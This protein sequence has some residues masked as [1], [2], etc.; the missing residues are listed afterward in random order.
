MF[1]LVMLL[2]PLSFGHMVFVNNALWFCSFAVIG[3]AGLFLRHL[4]KD[5][6]WKIY[7]AVPAGVSM[8]ALWVILLT[9][10]QRSQHK[11][12]WYLWGGAA[13]VLLM[14][15]AA[16]RKRYK[17]QLISLLIMALGFCLK[18]YYVIS[19]SIYTRQNDVGY[20]D[21]DYGHTGYIEYIYRHMS[22][23][24]FDPR[25]HWQYCHP[26]LHHTISA[27]WL[28]IQRELFA[29]GE[30]PARES[31]QMLSLFYS[32]CVMITAYRILCHFKLKGAALYI[33]LIVINFHPA[34]VLLSGSINND[35]LSIAFI[36][37]AVLCTLKWRESRSMKDILKLALC[38][39]L[40]MMTKISAALVSPPVALM[41]LIVFIKNSKTEVWKLIKQFV[42]FGLVC[43][44]LGMWF[45]VYER[46]RWDVP[47]AYVH[48]MSP[49]S[50]QYIGDMPFSE[51][52]TDFSLSQFSP[53]Y[54][55]WRQTD[56]FGIFYGDTDYNPLI[57][58]LKNCIFGESF[59][60]GTFAEYPFVYYLLPIFFC[61]NLFIAA[62]A[63]LSIIYFSVNKC[64]AAASEKAFIVS[65]YCLMM[66]SFYR[67]AADYP[68]TC[69]MNFRYI[70][71][72]AI[73][74]ALS[75]GF[76]ITALG[77]RR[78]K[79]RQPAKKAAGS[80]KQPEEQAAPVPVIESVPDGSAVITPPAPESAPRRER[81][82]RRM[83]LR[84]AAVCF[85]GASAVCFAL[86]AVTV[87]M[88]LC[89]NM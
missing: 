46:L 85:L 66:A 88:F 20:F 62:M 35:V 32:M 23:P 79:K 49:M 48:E 89:I 83:G 40:G 43:V 15:L 84:Q 38:I 86:C 53:I 51:R 77:R 50:Y 34:F 71:P 30:N 58:L 5:R 45:P 12:V 81:P 24:D 8:A 11:S 52:I 10:Y 59:G 36:M 26:P 76:T 31:I 33:P 63:F 21:K 18:Y 27:V 67:T 25:T 28:W 69:T 56:E 75:L 3:A 61:I 13:A 87:Y 19:T 68:F 22:L 37:G 17:E 29:V 70:T 60:D 57:T 7:H 47:F 41:F 72:T 16:D 55:H 44:P 74:G 65:F 2:T 82:R 9:L 1:A 78:E 73:I 54:E 14:F 42:C 80:A 6:G 4:V 64:R 39:G